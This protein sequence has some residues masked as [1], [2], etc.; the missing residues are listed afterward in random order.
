MGR[1]IF[2]GRIYFGDQYLGKVDP[3]MIAQSRATISLL[4]LAPIL[5]LRKPSALRL[6]GTHLVQFFVLGIVGLAASNYFYY[7][8]IE[9]TSVATAI[10]LQYV[11]PVWVLL[12][13]LARGLQRPTPQRIMGVALAVLGCAFAVGRNC[14]P[15]RLS[16]AGPFRSAFQRDGVIAAELAA[17]SFRLLQRLCAALASDLRALDGAGV[18]TFWRSCFLA[19]AKPAVEDHRATLQRR[20]VGVHGRVFDDL[21]AGPVFVLLRRTTTPRSNWGSRRRFP[22]TGLGHSADG[23]SAARVGLAHSGSRNG[24][25]AISDRADSKARPGSP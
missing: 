19:G 13:M 15:I 18:C 21:D 7:L 6:R 2:T 3:L 16:M 1:A 14:H 20:P 24:D 4:V 25:C 10:V 9:R 8:A 5:L 12:Y 23:N 22:G 17:I 11:A